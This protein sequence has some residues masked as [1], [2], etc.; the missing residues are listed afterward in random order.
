MLIT[1]IYQLEVNKGNVT[2]LESWRYQNFNF[3]TQFLNYIFTW[4]PDV[5]KRCCMFVMMVARYIRWNNFSSKS[6][7]ITCKMEV[8]SQTAD[9]TAIEINCIILSIVN[10]KIHPGVTYSDISFLFFW[11]AC[12]LTEQRK[13]IAEGR[14]YSLIAYIF[15]HSIFAKLQWK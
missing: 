2:A 11:K 15:T 14:E 13:Q 12:V 8:I 6:P 5:A 9:P 7:K 4:I 1:D 3:I 10:V